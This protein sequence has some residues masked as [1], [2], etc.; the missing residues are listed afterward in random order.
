MAYINDS[1]FDNGLVTLTSNTENLYIC[2]TEPTSFTQATTTYKLGTKATPTVGSP[3]NGTG[4]GRSI[5]I[6]AITDGIISAN[7]TAASWAITDNSASTL[8]ATGSLTAS[9]VV[10]DG[11]SFTLDAIEIRIADAA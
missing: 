8:L 9:Q 6:S 11:N 2:S 7:G 10:T 1:V 3:A 5:T 4:G